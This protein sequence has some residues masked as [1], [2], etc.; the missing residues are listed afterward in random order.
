LAGLLVVAAPATVHADAA[1]PSDWRSEIVSV[2][3]ATDAVT[4]T[5]EGGDAFVR[6]AVDPGHAVVVEGYADEPYLW[7]DGDGV[8][9]ENQRS[10]ATYYNQ[11]R[12]GV[13]ELPPQADPAA[14]PDWKVVGDDGAWAWHDH[15]A[16]WMGGSPPPGM[17]AGDSLTETVVPISVDGVA[18]EITVLT[19]LI[20]SPPLWPAVVGAVVGL[21]LVGLTL[22]PRRSLP[23]PLAIVPVAAAAT[24]I[25]LIQYRSLPPETGP[26]LIWWVPPLIAAVC[27]LALSVAHRASVLVRS[28]LVLISASQLLL[29][30][31]TRR[32][33][34]TRAV[35]PTSAPFWL[36]RMVTAAALAAG[37]ALI[38]VT[39]F[40]L[41]R[42]VQRPDGSSQPADR[43]TVPSR[44]P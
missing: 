42:L 41:A 19:T 28:G 26:R 22:M 32:T 12:S 18:T 8:V 25:G 43:I 27:G 9:H 44:T 20:G 17:S 37:L 13:A 29:W 14:E 5:I 40:A 36:D 31:W 3:P 11:N 23:V 16:H 6:I 2:T 10:P 38:A 4:V 33:G 7:T 35:L 15:R 39:V 21:A 24:I 30:G 34:I 1:G